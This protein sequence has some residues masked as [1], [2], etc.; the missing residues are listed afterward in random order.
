MSSRDPV[1]TRIAAVRA[2]CRVAVSGV[3]R[4]A[5]PETIGSSP[6]L[7][8][9]LADNSGEADLLFL[10][11]AAVAGLEPGCRCTAQG[12]ACAYQ[13]RLVIWNPRYQLEVR[14]TPRCE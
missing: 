5:T 4:S 12:R 10:G 8:C 11:H 6:A 13:G 3:V 1:V 2:Q 7:R 14:S 9:V